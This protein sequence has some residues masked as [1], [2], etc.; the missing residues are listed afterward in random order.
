[1]RSCPARAWLGWLA[2]WMIFHITLKIEVS[3]KP[4]NGKTER[5]SIKVC[6]HFCQKM[7]DYHFIT[8]LQS[9]AIWSLV[10]FQLVLLY[11]GT[12]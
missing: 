3:R 9:K 8:D 5:I 6:A 12:S 4:T 10:L 7:V 2:G 1:M 11:Y